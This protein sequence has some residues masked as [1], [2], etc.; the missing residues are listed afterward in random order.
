VKATAGCERAARGHRLGLVQIVLI[1]AR[2]KRQLSGI[3]VKNA[4]CFPLDPG[5]NC[6][7]KQVADGSEWGPRAGIAWSPTLL[8]QHKTVIRTGFGVFYDVVF[9]NIIDNI[10]ATAPNAA[11]PTIT[12][13]STANGHRGT[14]SWYE[15]F[16][17][18]N[19]SPLAGNT[20]EPIVNHLLSPRTMHWNLNIEQELPWSTT[21]QVGYVG[22]RGEHLY[23]NTNLN[24]FLNDNFSGDRVIPTRG[25]IIIRDNSD[26]SEYAG[27]WSELDHKFNHQFLFRASYTFGKAMDDGSEI[28]TTANESSYQFSQYPTPRGTTD[29]GPSEYDHRQRLVLSYIWTPAVWHTEGA[30]K[31]VGNVVN[32]WALAGV[33]QFQSGTAHNVEIGYDNDGDGISNDRPAVGNKKAPMNTYAF[34]ASWLGETPGTLC[35]GPSVWN[36]FDDC[37]VVSADSVH[38]VV[39]E[40]GTHQPN[41]IGRNSYFGPGYQQWDANVQRSFK[42]TERVTLDFR[43]ELFNA[44][45]HG[46]VDTSN[47]VSGLTLENTTLVSAIPSDQFNDFGT[48]TFATA[49]P[50]TNGHRHAR[51]FVRFSF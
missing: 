19:H 44:F 3:D 21:F 23:G 8:G 51:F 50:A 15:Q 47:S 7:T 2:I 1:I 39:G 24:P 45:N 17:N 34:D 20:A 32:H 5:S 49:E 18:L 14:A 30:M 4:A 35:S 16:A 42:L 31:I 28:F 9:T 27:L 13:S 10:Q 12:S 46:Q 22:E 48:N 6:N 38:W 43:G 36:S 25:S 41:A 29:W 40:F 37:H 26:D 11:S 33:T